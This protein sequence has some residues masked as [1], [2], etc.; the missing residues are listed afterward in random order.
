VE[1]SEALSAL[2]AR[3]WFAAL[4]F[5]V[6]ALAGLAVSLL[7]TPLYVAHTQLFVSTTDSAT[8]S[9]VLSGSEFSRQRVQSYALLL[10]GEDLAQRVVERLQLDVTASQL[11]AQVSATPIT[12]TVV[13]DV[14]VTDPDPARAEQIAEAVGAEFPP[15]ADELE[16]PASG[17]G[18]PVR[19]TVTDAPEVPQQPASPKVKRNVGLGAAAGLLVGAALAVLRVRLDRSVRTPAE[20]ADVAGAPVVGLIRREDRLQTIHTID[21]GLPGRTVEDYRCLR[22]NLQRLDEAQTPRVIMVSS[23]GP[24]EGKTTAVL[25]LAIALAEGGRRVTVVEAD[26][27]SPRITDYLGMVG[28][29]GLTDVL[30]GRAEL[31]DGLQ[32]YGSGR[33]YVVAA[34]PVPSNPGELLASS[35]MAAVLVK[36]RGQSDVVLVDAPPVLSVADAT[37]LSIMADGVLLVVRYGGT[38][39]D[40]LVAAAATLERAGATMLGVILNFVPS[41]GGSAPRYRYRRRHQ[42]ETAT[43][44][45]RR[46]VPDSTGADV[47][48]GLWVSRHRETLNPPTA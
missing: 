21:R 5:V 40:Q 28:D 31:D 37:D 48:Q 24:S 4:G 45:R 7:Q 17:D 14:A 29:V 33:M 19:V 22:T 42:A 23:A 13:I 36:L 30:T 9:A 39:K 25:N 32:R 44:R 46:P 2:R 18:S 6:G 43:R 12:D 41:S 35:Q 38:R 11:A 16:T 8:S 15:L 10:T 3:W 27:R 20:A 34:G 1:L 26:L 47:R